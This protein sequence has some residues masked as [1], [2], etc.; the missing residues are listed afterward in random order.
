MKY[1]KYEIRSI[2][3]IPSIIT[4]S[5]ALSYH[6]AEE[7]EEVKEMIQITRDIDF[8]GNY[9]NNISNTKELVSLWMTFLIITWEYILRI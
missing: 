3:L 1:R 6:Q 7:D 9:D 2:K 4:N 8:K 5:K